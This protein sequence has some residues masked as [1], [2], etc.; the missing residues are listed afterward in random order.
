VVEQ[1]EKI[2]EA[3]EL[4]PAARL[5]A[6]ADIVEFLEGRLD[7]GDFI[8]AAV[9]RHYHRELETESIEQ[10]PRERIAMDEF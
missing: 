1:I 7:P 5:H 6:K 8:N 10:Q 2:V 4:T 3:D 9:V